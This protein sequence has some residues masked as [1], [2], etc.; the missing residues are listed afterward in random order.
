MGLIPK[1]RGPYQET[2]W[3][4]QVTLWDDGRVEQDGEPS[5]RTEFPI[6]TLRGPAPKRPEVRYVRAPVHEGKGGRL[7][8]RGP[9]LAS[10]VKVVAE[11]IAMWKAGAWAGPGHRELNE[12]A[13]A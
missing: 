9:T 7:E 10:V 4:S 6:A 11:R 13:N 3:E 1:G 12:T 8:V 2:T 5:A